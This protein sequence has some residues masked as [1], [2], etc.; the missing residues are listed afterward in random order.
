[1]QAVRRSGGSII[2]V[3][4]AEILKSL[5]ELIKLGFYVE[6]TSAVVAAALL[7]LRRKGIISAEAQPVLELT[8]SGLKATDKLLEYFKF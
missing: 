2:S 8:G 7:Q 4:E 1:L 3:E 6:P 5:K